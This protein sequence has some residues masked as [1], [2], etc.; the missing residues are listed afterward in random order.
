MCGWWQGSQ[1]PLYLY[2]AR[3]VAIDSGNEAVG[4]TP[5]GPRFG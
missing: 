3:E 5:Y 2:E 1:G 4:P